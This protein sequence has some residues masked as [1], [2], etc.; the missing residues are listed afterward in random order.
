MGGNGGGQL[1]TAAGYGLPRL[2]A[3]KGP[4]PDR[5]QAGGWVEPL[6]PVP[7][8][9]EVDVG[10][11]CLAS[12]ERIVGTVHLHAVGTAWAWWTYLLGTEM[13]GRTSAALLSA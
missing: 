6:G 1:S 13:L 2:G 7:V 11:V 12:V 9:W 5:Q 8:D 4:M 3:P 10:A